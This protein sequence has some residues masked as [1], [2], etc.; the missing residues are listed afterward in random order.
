VSDQIDVLTLVTARLDQAAVSYMI[1]GSIAA[2]VYGQPRMTRDIDIVAALYP[3]HAVPLVKALTP[4][5]TCDLDTV[6]TA[7]A[8]RRIFN[9]IHEATAHKVDIIVRDDERAY[10][11][12]KFDR[13]RPIDLG[14]RT[15]WIIAPED[16]VL[17]KLVWAKDSRSELQLRD[18]ENIIA[19][20]KQ[21]DWAY[22]DRWAVRL[23]VSTLLAEVRP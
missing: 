19:L 18:V 16:L 20:Q 13:R 7:I 2:G 15:I 1:T 10:E 12:E 17:S 23:T 9:V 8:D 14:G 4:D 22:I 11:V 21:L 6:R 5:F 3:A